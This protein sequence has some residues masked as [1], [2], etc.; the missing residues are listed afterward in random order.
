M[1][2]EK[3]IIDG[4][5]TMIYISIPE[6][7]YETNDDMLSLEDTQIIEVVDNE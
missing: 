7:E 6:E 4:K 1:Q 5:E 2:T 3:V